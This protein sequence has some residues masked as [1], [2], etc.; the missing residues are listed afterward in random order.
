MS[1]FCVK[2]WLFQFLSRINIFL[3][4][5][6]VYIDFK[7]DTISLMRSCI[8]LLGI[9]VTSAIASA[10]FYDF[11]S[12][13]PNET[14]HVTGASS[15]GH[16]IVGYNEAATSRAFRFQQ[17]G[18]IQFLEP[19]GFSTFVNYSRA[20]AI[21]AN[22]SIVAGDSS[23][24]RPQTKWDN[25]GTPSTFDSYFTGSTIMALN[26]DGTIAAAQVGSG[27]YRVVNGAYSSLPTTGLAYNPLF[28]SGM[29]A[30]GTKIVATNQS[31]G[32]AP[33]KVALWR[34]GIGSVN[35]PTPN[36]FTY[37]NNA[38]ISRDGNTIV[39]G[40]LVYDSSLNYTLL[41]GL[42]NSTSV[43]AD[44]ITSTGSYIG[45]SSRD[46]S[47]GL[48]LATI[49]DSQRNPILLKDFLLGKGIN[50]NAFDMNDVSAI[51]EGPGGIS[52]SGT[53]R[54]GVKFRPFS[55]H[56]VPEPASLLAIGLGAAFLVRRRHRN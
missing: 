50:A 40:N 45:G 4:L 53:Y 55:V 30:D 36:L 10:Q 8:V 15:D 56:V 14:Y 44:S 7:S 25:V 46:G 1:F 2:I 43:T 28:V 48:D 47:S 9:L 34:Q 37:Y 12:G 38:R 29:S 41:S 19:T 23:G 35:L 16:S 39:T 11:T 18:V 22:A 54:T 21:S 52:I 20:F 32:I 5:S 13:L 42:A 51:E 6:F 31:T 26:A 27:A 49:W 17:G 33:D 3:L 24:F